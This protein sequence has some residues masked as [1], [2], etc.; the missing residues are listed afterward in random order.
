MDENTAYILN[1]LG[2]IIITGILNCII[3]EIIRLVLKRPIDKKQQQNMQFSTQ[4]SYI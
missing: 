3:P 1:V 2:S 4:F